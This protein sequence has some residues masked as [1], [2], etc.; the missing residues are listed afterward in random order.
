MKNKLKIMKRFDDLSDEE[1][2][3]HMNF[4]ALLT[5]QQLLVKTKLYWKIGIVGVTIV[6]GLFV[7]YYSNLSKE[8]RNPISKPTHSATTPTPAPINSTDNIPGKEVPV[9]TNAP[10]KSK[11]IIK[12][13]DSS[14]F[15][16]TE[17]QST[18]LQAEPVDGYPALYEYF[19]RNLIYPREVKSD[20]I[21]GVVTVSFI[22]NTQGEP[23]QV[24]VK[25][26]LGE[27]FEKEALRL[28]QKMPKWKPAKLNG[29][30]VASRISLPI[31]FQVEHVEL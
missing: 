20:S 23:E 2:S 11:A 17:K 5:K 30:P 19:A 21:H 28:V 4:D 26:S 7:F 15:S 29:K 12:E 16:V 6:M 27:P 14:D 18:Y 9:Q 24:T 10:A 8:S 13:N 3:Q 25:N 1:V 22:I 31:T